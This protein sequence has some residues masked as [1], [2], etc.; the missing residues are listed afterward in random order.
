[1]KNAQKAKEENAADYTAIYI[2]G[3]HGAMW[4]FPDNAQ[5]AK[6]TADIYEAN[7]VV[8][9]ICHGVIGL[10]NVKLCNWPQDPFPTC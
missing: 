4:D 3:G 7:G 8:G 5:L 1:M 2:A 6:L 10:T 9:A